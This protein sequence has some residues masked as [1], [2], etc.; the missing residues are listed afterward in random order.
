MFGKK[1]L[2]LRGFQ[3]NI[4]IG[5]LAGMDFLYVVANPLLDILTDQLSG[6]S[7]MT[8]QNPRSCPTG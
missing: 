7:V 3:L 1:Y 2:G 6:F 8:S 5:V 4:A